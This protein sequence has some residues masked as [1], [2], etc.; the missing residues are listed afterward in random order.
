[1]HI[2]INMDLSLERIQY[3]SHQISYQRD[4]RQIKLQSVSIDSAD[5]C[6]RKIKSLLIDDQKWTSGYLSTD[7]EGQGVFS[8]V[9]GHFVGGGQLPCSAWGSC[10]VQSL[11]FDV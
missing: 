9:L 8:W 7:I 2:I 4:S 10:G 6:R 3:I 11:L 1:M 5:I